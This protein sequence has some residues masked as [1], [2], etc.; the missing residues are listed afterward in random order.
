MVAVAD[1]KVVGVRAHGDGSAMADA[2]GRGA[3][4]IGVALDKVFCGSSVGGEDLCDEALGVE[5]WEE[6]VAD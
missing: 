5:A 2:A 1:V 3:V 4:G 6:D